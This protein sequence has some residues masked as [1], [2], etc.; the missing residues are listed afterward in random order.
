MRLHADRVDHPVGA[1]AIGH[2][3]DHLR[4]V[5]VL[6][7]VDRLDAVAAGHLQALRYGIDPDH[8]LGTLV[9]GDSRAHL[10]DRPEP[11]DGDAAALRD[12]RVLD[13]LP[14]GRQDVGEEQ[15]A[16]VRRPVLWHLDRPEV[17][18]GHP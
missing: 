13:R 17:G 4:H 9:A 15:V 2:L 10:S 18:L 11:V 16:L 12:R 5:F 7:R 6:G 8:R 3:P 14:G 1:T